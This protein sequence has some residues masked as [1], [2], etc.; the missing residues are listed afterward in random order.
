MISLICKNNNEKNQKDKF[1]DIEHRLVVA[2]SRGE[3]YG[4]NGMGEECQKV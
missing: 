2:R 1:I 4:M 3:G